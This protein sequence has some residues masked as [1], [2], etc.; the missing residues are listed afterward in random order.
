VSS[1]SLHTSDDEQSTPV[2][3]S[4]KTAGGSVSPL[5]LQSSDDEQFTPTSSR[6]S[7]YGRLRAEQDEQELKLKAWE[8][9]LVARELL[10]VEQAKEKFD[11]EATSEQLRQDQAR[12]DRHKVQLYDQDR[13]TRRNEKLVYEQHLENHRNEQLLRD[14]DK[15]IRHNAILL[16]EQD[17]E[18]RLKAQL[19]FDQDRAELN[20]LVRAQQM[21]DDEVALLRTRAQRADELEQA[22]DIQ[23]SQKTS[24][25][26]SVKELRVDLKFREICYQNELT[27]NASQTSALEVQIQD[28][29]Q[30]MEVLVTENI[31]ATARY[32]QYMVA[33]EA[34]INQL[35]EK[36]NALE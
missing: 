21:T 27:F 1:F 9:A 26:H 6:N 18:H 5:S 8:A 20:R 7:L 30:S 28:L 24:M 4:P 29:Q 25:L 2:T 19:L 34:K 13:E 3:P 35:Q 11:D 16:C 17:K 23:R 33:A 15:G 22:L 36:I 32:Q 12:Q 10:L 14:Q 31:D